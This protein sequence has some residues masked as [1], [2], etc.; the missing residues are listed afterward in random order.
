MGWVTKTK[1][2]QVTRTREVDHGYD[3][4]PSFR[5]RFIYFKFSGLRPNDSHWV[6]LQGRDVTTF[7]NT[8]FSI[9]D[10]NASSRSSVYRNPGDLYLE[11]TQFPADLGGPTGDYLTSTAQ[12]ELEGIFFLQSNETYSWNSGTGSSD[13]SFNNGENSL[14]FLVINVSDANKENALSYATAEYSSIGQ[15]INYT[16]ESYTVP[17][18]IQY[19][20]WRADPPRDNG[21]DDHNPPNHGHTRSSYAPTTSP[22]PTAAPRARSGHSAKGGYGRGPHG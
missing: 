1:T 4:N 17:V 20:E 21:R 8:S 6:F 19:K 10:F 7:I 18:K 12:G 22:R 13:Y 9:D 11:E 3:Y 14:P 5:S 2:V 15:Y 16:M